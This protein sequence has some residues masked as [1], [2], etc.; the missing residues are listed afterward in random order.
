MCSF[1][2]ES[3]RDVLQRHLTLHQDDSSARPRACDACH[4]NKTKCDG[5]GVSGCSFCNNKSIACKYSQR[6]SRLRKDVLPAKHHET[7]QSHCD[8]SSKATIPQPLPK[9]RLTAVREAP[10]TS[11]TANSRAKDYI[12][13][14][15]PSISSAETATRPSSPNGPDYLMTI[16]HELYASPPRSTPLQ[17]KDVFD[18][19]GQWL[20]DDFK[21]YVDRFHHRW[22]IITA[23]TYEFS[24]KPFDNAASV[25]MIGSF[26]SGKHDHN[27]VYVDIHRKLVDQYIQLLVSAFH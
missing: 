9:V 18:S 22:H 27:H 24:E 26:L 2:I 13:A 5:N 17:H 6:R 1:L 10:S 21:S 15:P 14:L 7:P 20:E 23:P 12:N 11:S 4:A 25:I 19:Q 3:T 8:T 16:L